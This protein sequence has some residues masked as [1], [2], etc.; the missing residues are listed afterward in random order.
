MQE[1]REDTVMQYKTLR[2]L[3]T[4]TNK[5]KK[6]IITLYI[7]YFIQ[8]CPILFLI[9]FLILLYRCPTFSNI[10]SITIWLPLSLFSYVEVVNLQS[11]QGQVESTRIINNKLTW[12]PFINKTMST[13]AKQQTTQPK[14]LNYRRCIFYAYENI[15]LCL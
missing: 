13:Q 7:H 3:V 10:Q 6:R 12:H 11:E 5:E 9:L 1:K 4:T 14:Q 8:Y 15:F 2:L